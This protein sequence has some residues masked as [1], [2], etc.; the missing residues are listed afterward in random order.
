MN[1][2]EENINIG[3]HDYDR[4]EEARALKNRQRRRLAMFIG[5]GVA[6][7]LII[8]GL[9]F[10]LT[11]KSAESR[12][13]DEQLEQMQLEMEMMQSA[14]ELAQLDREYAQLEGNQIN[15]M[16]NDSIVE[17]YAAAKAQVEKL[18]LELKNEKNKSAEQIAKLKAEIETLKGI[19][20]D[21]TQRIN[22]L[23]AENEGLREEN[24]QV[25]TR[26]EQLSQQVSQNNR[27]IAQQSERL[28]LA[29]K[30]NVTGLN[31]IAL[32]KKGKKEKHITKA[33]QLEVTFTIPQNNT[34]APGEKIIYLRITNPEGDL[35]TGNGGTFPFEGGQLE[36]TSRRSIEYANE[37]IGGVTMFWDVNTTLN[38]GDYTVELFCDGFRLDRPRH[39][40]M[41][42]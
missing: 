3:H 7:L 5:G 24:T 12:Q 4:E 27:T 40:Q 18:M 20:R 19:L 6:L 2:N 30:L 35:L 32:N 11:S 38:P 36:A 17:K 25:K 29:E 16:A 13:K 10:M 1:E 41:N 21:Y 22:E 42:K 8:G 23:M 15:L 34:T 28:T 39:F 26:N 31:L 9:V 14:N 37:E 33:T